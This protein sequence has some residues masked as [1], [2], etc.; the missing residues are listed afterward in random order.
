MIDCSQ[1][2]LLY[3]VF[4]SGAPGMFAPAAKAASNAPHA[5]AAGSRRGGEA[6]AR[7]SASARLVVLVHDANPEINQFIMSR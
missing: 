3:E 2:F 7:A 6:C 5:R 4:R 1:I